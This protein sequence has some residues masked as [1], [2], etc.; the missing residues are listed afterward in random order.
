MRPTSLDSLAQSLAMA[1]GIC[2]LIMALTLRFIRVKANARLAAESKV[3]WVMELALRK[4]II[5]DYRRLYP[6]GWGY[7]LLRTF[8]IVWVILVISA[9]VA[10]ILGAAI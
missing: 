6:G 3:S 1:A 9:I 8:F 7:F 2:F 5:A 4:Q 10:K